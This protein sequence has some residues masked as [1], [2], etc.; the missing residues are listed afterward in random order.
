MT[1]KERPA[2]LLVTAKVS[3]RTRMAAYTK[4]LADS[5]LY[6]R[7]GG[8][9]LFVGP[10]V[11]GVENWPDGQSGVLAVF[12]SRRAAEA[13]WHSA[14]YQDDIKPLRA[15]AGEFSVAIFEGLAG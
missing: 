14:V 12:P 7:H 10:P 6:A 4:A 1:E 15:G 11:D 3:D 2:Y 8:R 5:G 9:Y 13:F